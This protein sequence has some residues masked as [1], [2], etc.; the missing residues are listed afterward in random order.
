MFY[1]K[2]HLPVKSAL[3]AEYFGANT[4]LALVCLRRDEEDPR[5]SKCFI[6]RYSY[7]RTVEL[8][9]FFAS[10]GCSGFSSILAVAQARDRQPGAAWQ[11]RWI[12]T[13]AKGALPGASYPC[14]FSAR[15][16]SYIQVAHVQ[17]RRRYVRSRGRSVGL[18][19]AVNPASYS[20]VWGIVG[21]DGIIIDILSNRA[22][23]YE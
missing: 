14:R 7:D 8:R 15:S 21:H 1:C 11:S 13:P 22:S 5:I 6:T 4:L 3:P 10:A 12:L 17:G 16:A 2:I 19:R 23:S 18:I 9:E 20:C